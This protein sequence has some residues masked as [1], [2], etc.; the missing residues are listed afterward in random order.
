MKIFLAT[1]LSLLSLNSFSL[2]INQQAPAFT[3]ETLQVN[4]EYVKESVNNSSDKPFVLIEFMSFWCRACLRNLPIIND[5]GL[6]YKNILNTKFVIID[7]QLMFE[8]AYPNYK[9]SISFPLALDFNDEARAL[10]EVDTYPEL[11]ILDANNTV[12]FKHIGMLDASVM[13]DLES[14]FAQMTNKN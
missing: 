11:L 13:Q 3:L 5:F 8:E 12:I 1:F 10:Y 4:G 6:R 9:N 2:E 7:D 14:L